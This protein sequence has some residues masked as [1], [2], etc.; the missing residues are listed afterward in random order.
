MFI[1]LLLISL[2]SFGSDQSLD[3]HREYLQLL[4]DKIEE[5]KHTCYRENQFLSY[6]EF[7][8][9]MPDGEKALFSCNQF[10][11]LLAKEITKL[12][13]DVE[14]YY[15]NANGLEPVCAQNVNHLH[16]HS[17]EDLSRMQIALKEKIQNECVNA[18]IDLLQCSKDIA[19]NV[20]SALFSVMDPFVNSLWTST[21]TYNKTTKTWE[22]NAKLSLRKLLDKNSCG[23]KAVGESDCFQIFA[24][25]VYKFIVT[26]FDAAKSLGHFLIFGEDRISNLLHILKS[27][28]HPIDFVSSVASDYFKL[29]QEAAYY[30]FGCDQWEGDNFFNRGKCLKPDKTWDCMNCD[31][32]LNVVCGVM[33]FVL[34]QPL[35]SYII[36]RIS[37]TISGGLEVTKIASPQIKKIFDAVGGGKRWFQAQKSTL[38]LKSKMKAVG[39][40]AFGKMPSP[41]ILQ[42]YQSAVKGAFEDGLMSGKHSVLKISHKLGTSGYQQAF[43]VN[44]MTQHR[45]EVKEVGREFILEKFKNSPGIDATKLAD[46][47][48][49][50]I[51]AVHDADKL[52]DPRVR[53]TLAKAYG[54]N[55]VSQ[56]ERAVVNLLNKLEDQRRILYVQQAGMSSQELKF[57]REVEE[58][59]DHGIRSF[60]NRDVW[61]EAVPTR[62]SDEFGRPTYPLVSKDPDTLND[63]IDI[64]TIYRN[65]FPGLVAY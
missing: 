57:I 58:L 51:D 26:L 39:P 30:H 24:Q 8:L 7:S 12:Q 4:E 23:Y 59:A 27:F 29:V 47:Y 64:I 25:G 9:V 18:G 65:R 49:K 36:G 10:K 32:Q 61:L 43:F 34:G 62:F 33:G 52:L 40:T 56:E 42:K 3:E 54:K 31:Q 5:L 37:G 55:L 19:C 48:I 41:K 63:V 6:Y 22:S 28:E 14:T 45:L 16:I 35:S 17:W 44:K 50:Y 38:Y 2:Q 46:D 60:G 15:Q 11:D 20:N 21:T 1:F 53:A 13:A